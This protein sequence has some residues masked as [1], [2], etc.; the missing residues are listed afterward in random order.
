M[1]G[2]SVA[3][4]DA[5]VIPATPPPEHRA[6]QPVHREHAPPEAHPERHAE[7]HE[8][9]E[10]A[11]QRRSWLG[12]L[13]GAAGAAIRIGIS[14][15]G[16]LL[17]VL[18]LIQI[19]FDTF[20]PTID[21]KPVPVPAALERAGYRADVVSL[22]LADE[23]DRIQKIA[24]T[25]H[26]RRTLYFD[27]PPLDLTMPGLGFSVSSISNYIKS[28]LSLQEVIVCDITGED[29]QYVMNI[30]D[31]KTRNA[32][33]VDTVKNKDLDALIADG[34]KDILRQSDPYVLASFTR[35]S[36]PEQAKLLLR[37]VIDRGDPEDVAWAYLMWGVIVKVNEHNIPDGLRYYQMAVDA[38][39]AIPWYRRWFMSKDVVASAYVNMSIAYHDEE[40]PAESTR[41]LMRAV[42]LGLDN[43]ELTLGE[44]YL[45]G[46][47]VPRDPKAAEKWLLR[48]TA[49][50]RPEAYYRLALLYLGDVPNTPE[51]PRDARQ[52]I[53]RLRYAAA[54]GFV[55]AEERLGEEYLSGKNLPRDVGE[56]KYWLGLAADK[57]NGE[58]KKQLAVLA[59]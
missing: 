18:V 40:K 11:P 59:P 27:R 9:A 13:H 32:Q 41:Y 19:A 48:A 6:E 31:R 36:N 53:A 55:E 15:T 20:Y 54:H 1:E 3:V 8:A 52:G 25:G 45:E 14:V 44:R 58:A 43:A 46:F 5:A 30:R 22:K 29:G 33:T 7:Q 39:R 50:G 42:A 23:I 57:G 26:R 37:E 17:V 56:A 51:I 2:R 28:F 35:T 47:G 38:F 24:P 34:A 21:I 4:D 49:Q 10:P 16:A 12:T